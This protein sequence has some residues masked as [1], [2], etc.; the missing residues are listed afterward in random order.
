MIM[1]S[2][3]INIMTIK[4]F[5]LLDGHNDNFISFFEVCSYWG[6]VSWHLLDSVLTFSPSMVFYQ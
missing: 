2:V 4:I 1:L 6:H 5:N 3:E